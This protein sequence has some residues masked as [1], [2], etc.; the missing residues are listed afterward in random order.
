MP[1]AFIYRPTSAARPLASTAVSQ[2]PIHRVEFLVGKAL[3][4]VPTLGIAIA[5]RSFNLRAAQQFDIFA[6][7]PHSASPR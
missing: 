1:A 5:A 3:A 2:S 4:V 6:A 7:F